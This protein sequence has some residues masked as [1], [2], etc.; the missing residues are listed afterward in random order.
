MVKG[1]SAGEGLTRL[2]GAFDAVVRRGDVGHART[3]ARKPEAERERS[4]STQAMPMQ[5]WET[6]H[7]SDEM[8]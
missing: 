7:M 8:K 1:S 5:K 4:A 3:G 6:V 2:Y